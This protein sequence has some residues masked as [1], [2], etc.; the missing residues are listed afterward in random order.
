M[1]LRV[2]S[3]LVLALMIGVPALGQEKA[4]DLAF[5]GGI[6]L[7]NLKYDPEIDPG[8]ST[9]LCFGGG[10]VLSM[11]VTEG[12]TLDVGAFYMQK[13]AKMEF[14]EN[15]GP[16]G[17]TGE[18]VRTNVDLKMGYFLINPMLRF[19]KHGDGIA[20]YLMAGPEVGFLVSA[21]QQGTI[22][23]AWEDVVEDVDE[24]VKDFYKSTSLGINIGAGFM[25]PSGSNAFILEARYSLGL[26]DIREES[27]VLHELNDEP[28]DEPTVKH[29]GIYVMGGI[30][31]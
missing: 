6:N 2:A 27:T 17:D 25:I 11:N 10:A 19:T 15:F 9:L 18:I 4:F 23:R 31:F 8:T 5:Q 28:V 24:D 30:R 20:P 29:N 14:E 21:K 1:K 12:I 22:D 7:D 26:T 3:V 13:G 16:V